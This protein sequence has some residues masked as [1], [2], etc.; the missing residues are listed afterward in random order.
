MKICKPACKAT[1]QSKALKFIIYYIP[2]N[3]VWGERERHYFRS[4]L[5]GPLQT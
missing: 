1:E 2:D 3:V 5:E 4:A